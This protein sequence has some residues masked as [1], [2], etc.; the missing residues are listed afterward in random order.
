MWVRIQARK[1]SETEINAQTGA[2][3]IVGDI[4]VRETPTGDLL[5]LDF[6]RPIRGVGG[7]TTCFHG[8]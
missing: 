5:E 6:Q 2:V 3:G 1:G 7:E 4:G 8:I